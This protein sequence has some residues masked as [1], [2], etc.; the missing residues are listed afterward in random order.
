MEST[1]P[2]EISK[3]FPLSHCP[4]T[5]TLPVVASAERVEYSDTTCGRDAYERGTHQK[6]V[7]FSFYGNTSSGVH[8]AKQYFIGIKENLSLVSQ[9]YGKDWSMRLYYDL[10]KDDPLLEDLCSLACEQPSLD[11][12]YVRDLPGNPVKDAS[13]VFAMNWRFLPTLDPQ[14]DIFLCRDLDSRISAREVAA[15]A[16]WLE[17]DQPI[18]SMRDHPA[19]TTPILGAAWGAR[20]TQPNIRHKWKRSWERILGDKL[21]YAPRSAKGPDQ[22]LLMVYVWSWGKH[23]A[24]EHDSYR[25]HMYPHSIG[26]P[27][28]RKDEDN[29]FVASVVSE[30]RG[31]LWKKCPKKCRRKGHEDWEHC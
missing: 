13:S 1:V 12:C 4:C 8:K 31:Y 2:P 18:H 10:E 14:V 28:E 15:V 23:M 27:T 25:C 16:E 30:G 22:D 7:G 9:L 20:I 5:R 29:N 21:A 26:F 6:V 17:S 11:L 3:K 19:H 24:M